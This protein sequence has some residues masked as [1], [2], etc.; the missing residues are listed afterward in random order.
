MHEGWLENSF[1]PLVIGQI[2]ARS[3]RIMPK[4]I[5]VVAKR[6]SREIAAAG[7]R[8]CESIRNHGL[9]VVPEEALARAAKIQG[10][11]PLS[12]I[13]ADLMVTLG[14]DGTVLKVVREMRGNDTPILGV[15]M[16]QRGYLTE[17]DPEGFEVAFSKWTKGDFQ[18]E[19][20]W[21]VSVLVNNNLVGEG[22]NEALLTPTVPAKMLR[23]EISLAGKKLFTASADGLIVATPT[24]STAH[25]FSAG[26][27][28][29]EGSLND[30]VISFLAPL[31]PV[32]SLV[33]PSNKNLRVRI[34]KPGQDANLSIDG[35]LERKVGLGQS[36]LFRK[37]SN[38]A[39]FVR[40]GD[41]F[42]QRSLR[43]LSP[44]KETP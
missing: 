2:P 14:G 17:V 3:L 36:V 23:L 21:K 44:E 15:N 20:L 16:G 29:L 35:R 22:L 31:H 39:S 8:I 30:L 43:R 24:G 27:P 12:R 26:G 5:G 40:F 41:S 25:S 10:G 7:R 9:S 28:V 11:K 34:D 6:D 32:R 13:K 18:L 33:L 4:T 37:S 19:R 38:N 42:L 1:Q